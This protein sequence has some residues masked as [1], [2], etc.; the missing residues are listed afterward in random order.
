MIEMKKSVRELKPYRVNDM[1]YK[2]KLDAN[3][4]KNYIFNGGVNIKDIE[5]NIYPDSDAKKLRSMMGNYYGCKKENIIVG[6]GSSDLINIVINSYCEINDKVLSFNPSFSMY[7]IYCNLCS[8]NYITIPCEDDF[9][10]NIDKL[11]DKAN[12]TSPKVV[13]ICTPNN[14]TGFVTSKEDIVKVLENIKNSIVIVDEAYIDFG[15]K[16]VIDLINKYD[17][18]IVMRT[19]SKAFGLAALRV[20]CLIAN[21]KLINKL[22]KVKVPYNLNAIS[23]YIAI[24]SFENIDKIQKYIDETI[25]RREKLSLNLSNLGLRVFPS[26]ANYLFV[27]SDIENLFD[28]LVNRGILI[29]NFS[30]NL[31]NY[32]RITVGDEMENEYLIKNMKEIIDAKK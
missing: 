23:Q 14:P 4:G 20:G 15:G 26:G 17:N 8:S 28:K 29:R 25:L 21:E 9:T 27:Y 31:S 13:I 5:L 32:Y 2:V 1:D 7:Q 10:Q 19:L 22:W 6:N 30:K 11:I 18:I 3:E 24:K 16:S 12:E